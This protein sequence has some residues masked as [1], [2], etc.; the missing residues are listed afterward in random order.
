[1]FFLQRTILNSLCWKNTWLRLQLTLLDKKYIMENV[2]LQQTINRSLI[3]EPQQLGS[4]LVAYGS[5]LAKEV[6]S[7]INIQPRKKQG[8]NWILIMQTLV[9]NYF[10]QTL[11]DVKWTV[12]STGTASRWYQTHYSI[13]INNIQQLENGSWRRQNFDCLRSF[14]HIAKPCLNTQHPRTNIGPEKRP[15]T[16]VSN[17]VYHLALGTYRVSLYVDGPPPHTLSTHAHNTCSNKAQKDDNVVN[18]TCSCWKRSL[19]QLKD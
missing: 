11:T 3:L 1:M 18:K 19:T 6:F 12:S 9:K 14:E 17:F 7:I 5:T 10:L 2:V 8:E 16:F 15:P 4:I 13:H